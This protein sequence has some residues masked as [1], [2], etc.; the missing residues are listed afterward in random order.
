MR[1]VLIT[2][3]AT[4]NPIDAMRFISANASGR[5]GTWLATAFEPAQVTLLCSPEA[6]TRAPAGTTVEKFGSTTDLMDQMHGWIQAHP[7]GIVVHSAAVGDYAVTTPEAGKKIPS[8]QSN[9]QLALQ[10]TPK[11]L[12]HI[13]QWSASL[14]LVSFKAAP[15]DT[16]DEA[17]VQMTTAQLHRTHSD[18]VFGNT[19]KRIQADVILVD[20]DGVER[21]GERQEALTHLRDRLL[22]Q[23]KLV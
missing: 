2:A 12:D 15:P 21:F 6:V 5:T 10:P 4:R 13:K 11:I 16:S 23:C 19:L 9:L 1:P 8:G 20:A 3:G 7:D 14:F 17:L 22:Q 18:L